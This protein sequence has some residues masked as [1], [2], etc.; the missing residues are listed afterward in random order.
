M[1]NP[2]LVAVMRGRMQL[3]L[4]FYCKTLNIL[5]IE[6]VVSRQMGPE[7]HTDDA[8]LRHINRFKPDPQ[9]I[10]VETP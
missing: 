1:G 6:R 9:F 5:W 3:A 8:C 10:R 2:D 4:L 7:R